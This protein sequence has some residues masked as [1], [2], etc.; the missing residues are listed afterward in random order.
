LPSPVQF[1]RLALLG[2]GYIGGSA[3][4][5]ARQAGLVGQI[6]GYDTDSQATQ[7]ARQAG[8][9]D[10]VATSPEDAA[11]GA[12]LV[13]L[14]APV[15]SLDGLVRRLA[16]VLADDATVIDVGSVKTSVVLAAEAV[17]PGGQFVGCHPMAGAEFSG[18]DA[19]DADI[20]AGRVCFICP[21]RNAKCD[22]IATAHAFWR[23]IGCQTLAID[24]EIHDR[25]MA[26]QSHLPHV[27]AFALSAALA[28]DLPFLETS[29]TPASPTTSLRDTTRIASSGPKVW[30]DI[31]LANA[32]HVLPLIREL[33]KCVGEIGA[34]VAAGDG[35]A[36]ESVL[37]IGQTCRRRLVKE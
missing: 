15:Q 24:P 35:V 3:A 34:A 9:V 16:A 27:A 21:A 7:A 10:T 30:R 14:A 6:V 32:S 36:L 26:A 18:V 13:L 23:G 17:L 20:F 31:L 29:A 33:E 28:S 25:L 11:R 2:V 22:A 5:A 1:P 8:I 19:A 12:S 37:S 4:L